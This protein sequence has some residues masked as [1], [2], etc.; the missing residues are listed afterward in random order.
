MIGIVLVRSR[1]LISSA[2]SNPSMPGICTSSRITAKSL[3]SRRRSASSPERRGHELVPERL[4]DRLQREQVLRAVVDEQQGS[5]RPSPR[6]AQLVS[7]G[8]DLRDRS[9][10]CRRRRARA[11]RAG[12]SA[13]CAVAGSWTIA[14]PPGSGRAQAERTVVIR[15]GE[16]DAYAA[17]A[18]GRR[19]PSRSS[20]SIDGRAYCTGSSVDNANRPGS[21][22]RW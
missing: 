18:V 9:D 1:C 19:R 13:R 11:R 17:L 8:R 20:T 22:S 6:S 7:S 15:A 12:I 2:V 4:E 5:I 3:V 10:P 16:H 21:T 14:V